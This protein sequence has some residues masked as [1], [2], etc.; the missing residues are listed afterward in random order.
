M[1]GVDTVTHSADADNDGVWEGLSYFS[2]DSIEFKYTIDD[3]DNEEALTS[4][5][6]CTKTT[7]DSQIAS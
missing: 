4:G 2:A 7:A 3:W 1:V 5:G 6:S